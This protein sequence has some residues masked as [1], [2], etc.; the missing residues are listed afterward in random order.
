[1]LGRNADGGLWLREVE[2]ETERQQKENA[3]QEYRGQAE[4]RRSVIK[5][6]KRITHQA[7]L[8]QEGCG[9]Y[10]ILTTEVSR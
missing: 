3:G 8:R 2:R 5:L 4:E 7:K 1:M 10:I 6:E 9:Q